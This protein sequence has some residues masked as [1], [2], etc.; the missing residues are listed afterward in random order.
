M[1]LD[2]LANEQPCKSPESQ[3]LCISHVI[4]CK[5]TEQQKT[6]GKLS[7]TL[8]YAFNLFITFLGSISFKNES[9]HSCEVSYRTKQNSM[10]VQGTQ[11]SKP[12]K[13]CFHE[14]SSNTYSALFS[15][16]NF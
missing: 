6:N 13:L 9:S 1:Y 11:F 7:F 8:F 3:T 10:P 14:N 15:V 4:V 16:T 5:M 2:I 12:V